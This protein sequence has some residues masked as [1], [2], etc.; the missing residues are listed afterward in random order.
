MQWLILLNRVFELLKEYPE[1]WEILQELFKIITG[2]G[3][4]EPPEVKIQRC[5]AVLD[6]HDQMCAARQA[7]EFREAADATADA[8]LESKPQ[9]T[10]PETDAA[11]EAS[12]E[13][14]LAEPQQAAPEAA[15]GR[16]PARPFVDD[17]S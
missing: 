4:D 5:Y 17:P 12:T 3:T 15:P 13:P 11:P 16:D 6:R 7:E 8:P 14:A 10:S 9:D 1:L 2:G